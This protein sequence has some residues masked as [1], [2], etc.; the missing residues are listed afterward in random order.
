MLMITMIGIFIAVLIGLL[1]LEPA[2]FQAWLTYQQWQHPVDRQ[3]CF[4][5]G[6]TLPGFPQCRLRARVGGSDRNPTEKT[7]KP[8]SSYSV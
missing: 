1:G 3:R 5:N 8:V 2:A 4:H 7:P 6:D